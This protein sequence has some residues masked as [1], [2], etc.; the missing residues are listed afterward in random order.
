M[1]RFIGSPGSK[2]VF[3]ALMAFFVLLPSR[4][5]AQ[6]EGTARDYYDSAEQAALAWHP[7]SELLYLLG[8]GEEMH[9][10]GESILWM[11]IFESDTDDSMLLVTVSLGIPLIAEE[12]IDT[13]SVLNP[14]PDNWVDSDVAVSVAEANGGSDWRATTGSNLLIATAGRGF[15]LKDIY[16]PVWLISYSD[17]T[18]VGNNLY[19]HVDA[20]TGEFIESGGLDVDDQPE[21]AH[22]LPKSFTLSDNYPNPFNPSTTLRYTIPEGE[23]KEIA[24][25]IYDMRGRKVKTLFSGLREAGV[26]EV[27]WDGKDKNGI[28][29]GSGI[30]LARLRSDVVV[31]IRK[32]VLAK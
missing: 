30:Y 18:E 32:M 5:F 15:Y 13:I 23:A 9:L 1:N 11:Y 4:S 20:V 2:I 14:L 19:I 26:Y 28:L 29:V 7:D 31:T 17:T 8:T 25:E 6:F 10:A 3:L 27:H 22:E 21:T 24:I 12:I 16:R